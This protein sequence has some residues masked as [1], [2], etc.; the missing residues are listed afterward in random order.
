VK[1]AVIRVHFYFGPVCR[2][3]IIN[4]EQ[5]FESNKI[6]IM[7]RFGIGAKLSSTDDKK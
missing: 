7:Q 3:E 6:E 1:R 4:P 2:S 5:D